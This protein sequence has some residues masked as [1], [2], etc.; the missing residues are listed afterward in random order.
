M[1]K[2]SVIM[3]SYNCRDHIKESIESILSQTYENIELIICDDCSTDGTWDIIKSYENN[4]KIRMFRNDK[5]M[6]SAYTRNRCISESYGEFI[7]IQDADD[8]SEINRVEEQVDFLKKNHEYGFVGSS[9]N[10]FNNKGVWAAKSKPEKPTKKDFLFAIPFAHASLM[11]RAQ[12]LKDIGGY[13]VA[14]ETRRVEDY[15]MVMR[16]YISGYRGYNLQK[17]LY[18]YRV[19][20]ETFQ[21]RKLRY[22]IDEVKVRYKRFNELGLFPIGIVYAIK[23]IIVGLIPH[24]ILHKIKSN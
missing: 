20:N 3:A 12:V 13:R 15:D 19:D 18:N 4:S 2:V 16:S 22:R 23:P 9:I 17:I 10:L 14:K 1:E 8:I 6:F 21:R 5:N 11:F 7:M 24:K